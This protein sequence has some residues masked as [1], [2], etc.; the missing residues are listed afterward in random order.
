[1]ETT[2][3]IINLYSK[4]TNFR[5]QINPFPDHNYGASLA[6]FGNMF[7]AGAPG[8]DPA[9]YLLQGSKWI[10]IARPENQD[11]AFGQAVAL[12]KDQV[13]IGCPGNP[14]KVFRANLY[15]HSFKPYEIEEIVPNSSPDDL[16][17]S[18]LAIDGKFIYIGSPIPE[19]LQGKGKI[20]RVTHYGDQT[21]PK[22]LSYEKTK[23]FG[24]LLAFGDQ[25]LAVGVPGKPGDVLFYRKDD[26]DKSGV[27]LK[28]ESLKQFK[29]GFANLFW[30]R[31]ALGMSSDFIAIGAP[32]GDGCVFLFSTNPLGEVVQEIRPPV[33]SLRKGFGQCLAIA[34]QTLVVGDYSQPGQ[35]Y[36]YRYSKKSKKW[37]TTPQLIKPCQQMI[38]SLATNDFFIFAG[39]KFEDDNAGCVYRYDFN[40]D[41]NVYMRDNLSDDGSV[42]S[43]GTLWAS[44]DIIPRQD[45]M[46]N[47][48]QAFGK[49]HWQESNLGQNVHAGE[50]NYVYIRA[51]NIGLEPDTP[52]AHLFIVKGGGFSNPNNWTRITPKD[53]FPL[54]TI[55]PKEKAV[56][57]PISWQA[58]PNTGHFCYVCYL[59]SS[60]RPFHLPKTFSSQDEY[61]D[62]VAHHNNLCFHNVEIVAASDAEEGSVEFQMAGMPGLSHDYQLQVV[63]TD[64]PHG[65]TLKFKHDKQPQ[66]KIVTVN[67]MKNIPVYDKITLAQNEN[68][69]VQVK[70]NPNQNG[71]YK[72][73]VGQLSKDGKNL[74]SVTY[75]IHKN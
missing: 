66:E 45:K 14:G 10:R 69:D 68:L 63:E 12:D 13:F 37:S 1:M 59:S 18:A 71:K 27:M 62:Y 61:L 36:I 53:G 29:S 20:L 4:S 58:P 70:M 44:P 40:R 73:V 51:E 57:G 11:G 22:P 25:G 60:N 28:P 47:Y 26:L 21:L 15:E 17:G 50:E 31:G 2:N 64:L 16:L 3:Q 7:V 5:E 32:E 42:P 48:K 56:F 52:K 65:S 38:S 39:S 33:S 54:N 72:V 67:T 41:Y 43:Y 49:N 35:A 74:G 75:Y 23:S 6:V 46:L 55:Q 30:S 34:D 24:S 8:E 9:V 19:Q